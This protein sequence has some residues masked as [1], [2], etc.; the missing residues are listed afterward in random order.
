MTDTFGAFSI[1]VLVPGVAME[2]S[3][4]DYCPGCGCAEIADT[5]RYAGHELMRCLKC[6]LLFEKQ[7]PT[8]DELDSFYS[9][10][11]Y[12]S[13]KEVPRS[14]SESYR[15]VIKLLA[16]GLH[17]PVLLDY[18]CGQGSFL[19]ECRRQS[20][21]AVGLE[22]SSSARLLCE[23]QG[24]RV[25][26]DME[27][28][29]QLFPK[30]FDVIS[31]FEVV[32]HLMRPREMLAECHRALKPGGLLYLTTPNSSGISLSL[33][34]GSSR[35]LS[36]PEH[37]CLF[38]KRSISDLAEMSGFSVAKVWSTGI[39]VS[40]IRAKLINSS[41]LDR[42]SDSPCVSSNTR[43]ADLQLNSQIVSSPI[44][45]HAKKT[46]NKFL[47]VLGIGDT[48]KVLLKKC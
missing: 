45:R 27:S 29:L 17:D 28:C 19:E 35:V 31:S 2:T 24:L 14:V 23:R 7:I 42:G 3:F 9:C 11:S 33:L 21:D 8:A 40:E 46:L 10:Y 15:S 48:L 25:M 34:G 12:S 37:L 39:S 4:R 6:S 41:L 1:I 47:S 18:G 20:V 5:D 44:G 38:N 36:Y 22:V 16:H 26:A 30:G 13:L 32:E 43:A